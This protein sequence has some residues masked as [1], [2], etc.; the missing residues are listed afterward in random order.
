MD[1]EIDKIIASKINGTATEADLIALDEWLAKDSRNEKVLSNINGFFAANYHDVEIINEE[2]IREKIWQKAHKKPKVI[3]RPVFS[4]WARYAAAI[5]ILLI[6]GFASFRYLVPDYGKDTQLTYK[7]IEKNTVPG[8]KSTI[9]LPDGSK[10]ILNSSSKIFFAEGFNDS[11]RWVKLEGEGYFEVAKNAHK[12]FVVQSGDVITKALGTIFNIKSN[13]T[14][15]NVS[16]LEGSVAVSKINTPQLKESVILKPGEYVAYSGNEMTNTGNFNSMDVI[17]WK[18][19]L[20]IFRNADFRTVVDKLE[21]WY[22]VKISISGATPKWSLNGTYD[23]DN[24]ENILKA[25]GHSQGFDYEI[26][27]NKIKITFDERK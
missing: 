17:G 3:S 10:V 1:R 5:G 21:E 16:L 15:V 14:D 22:G 27:G 12:P 26:L 11:V 7:V 2:E 24:L 13:Q 20:L 9:H 8:V 19:G 18:D 25:L 23:N 6:A 4:Y